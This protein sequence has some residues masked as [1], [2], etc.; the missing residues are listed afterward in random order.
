M[1]YLLLTMLL[2]LTVHNSLLLYFNFIYKY[3]NGTGIKKKFHSTT[4]CLSVAVKYTLCDSYYN[5]MSITNKYRCFH[6]I[7]VE[8]LVDSKRDI[9]RYTHIYIYI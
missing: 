9:N 8:Y 6:Y 7:L 3:Y 1:K 5:M 4:D 2:Q